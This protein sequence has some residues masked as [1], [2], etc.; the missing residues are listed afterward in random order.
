MR[1]NLFN[2]HC[3]F[4][5]M[6]LAV[7]TMEYRVDEVELCRDAYK[8]TERIVLLP[9]FNEHPDIG[10]NIQDALECYQ[11]VSCFFLIDANRL[12]RL[13]STSNQGNATP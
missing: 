11:E 9:G 7:Y 6:A 2:H 13:Q 5:F 1:E 8:G 4:C 10:D 12:G 3:Y